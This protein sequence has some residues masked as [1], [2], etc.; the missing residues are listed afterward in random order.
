LAFLHVDTL[1]FADADQ[2]A[3]ALYY[4]SDLWGQLN[5]PDRALEARTTLKNRYAGTRWA[6]LR[7]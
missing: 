1:F 2:H 5:Q 3:Q 6:K 7:S 4:L